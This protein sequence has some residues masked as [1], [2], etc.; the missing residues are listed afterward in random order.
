MNK[1]LSLIIGSLL[2]TSCSSVE[3]KDNSG[4]PSLN[5]PKADTAPQIDGKLDDPAWAKAAVINGLRPCRGGKYQ[6][7]ID[8][9]PTTIRLLWDENY[10]YVAYECT[11]NDIVATM[12]ERDS[13]LY[14]ED[15]CEVFIDPK[16]D[17][18]QYFEVQVSPNNVIFDI[19]HLATDEP[20]YTEQMR[21]TED[22]CK[23]DRWVFTEWN[24]D[25]LK[26]ATVR[27]EKGWNCEIAIPAKHIMKR[28]AKGKDKLE[29]CELR[30]N[31]MRYDHQ[32]NSKT[33]KRDLVHMNWAP[34]QFGCPHI[35]PAAMGMLNLQ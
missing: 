1:L 19:M 2:L 13:L 33:G 20:R 8:K 18:R 5:V 17:G 3:L 9:V 34:V 26:T 29:P 28:K 6:E 27:T 14:Q 10:L 35:S 32:P 23:S 30:A 22:F 31:F 25:G 15:V 21:F 16:G 11:D 4:L 12:T 7:K 24:M